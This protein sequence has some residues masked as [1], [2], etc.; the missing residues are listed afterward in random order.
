MLKEALATAPV[1]ALPNYTAPFV[2]E[3]DACDVGIG[4]VLSQK[5]HP[6]AFVSRALGPKNRG[7][8]VYE[9]EYMAILLAVQQWRS[10]LQIG[11]FVIKTDH[12]SLT[13]LTNQRLHTEWQHRALTKLMGLQYTVQYKKG[14]LNGA[15]DALSRKPVESSP[16]MVATVV[17]PVW[18]DKVLDSYKNDSYAQQL[19]QKLAIDSQAG[20]SFTL[21]KGVLR[22][23]GRVW[24]GPDKEVQ[25]T[26]IAAFHDSLVGGHS[27]FPVTYRRLLSLFKWPGMKSAVKE[28]VAHCHICQQAKPERSLP[29]GLLQPLLIPSGPW[30]M[31][32]MDFIDGLPPSWQYNCILVVVDK[33]SEYA[34]FIPL[35]HSYAAAKVAEV[36][37]DNIYKL[38]GMPLTLVSDRDPVFT[39]NFWQAIFRATGTQLNLSTANHPETDGQTERVNQ[40]I[41]CYLRCFISAHPQQWSKWLSLCE[42]WYNNNWHSSLGKTPFQVIYGR[43]PRYFGITATDTVASGDIQEWLH[44][45]A[46]VLDSVKQHLLRMQQRMKCQADKKRSERVFS[47]GDRIFLKLQPYLQSSVLRRANHKLASSSSARSK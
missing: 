7:L 16:L 9:K 47:V 26:I 20:P 35:R 27:G 30:D 15:A 23:Q 45:R 43:K 34:H 22:Y 28:F 44:E 42:F 3:T 24:I 39:S 14:I 31:A 12:K 38:H 4:V 32:T 21:S 6:L 19:I 2:I 46:L 17:Q 13:H 11:E 8:S 10:Y 18:L 37:V 36:F 29:A 5:G 41:E 25:Q 40:S 33:L 1:L